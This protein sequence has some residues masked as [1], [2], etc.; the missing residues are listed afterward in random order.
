MSTQFE[1]PF[2]YYRL[3]LKLLSPQLGTCTEASIY[4]EHVLK[5]AQK[6]IKEAN[7][8]SGKLTKLADKY[9]GE[10][11]PENKQVE[12][13]KGIIKRQQEI[14]GKADIL[15]STITEL[16]AYASTLDE[17]MKELVAKGEEKRP[18]IF[19]RDPKTGEVMISTHMLLGNLKENCRNFINNNTQEKD[20]LPIKSKVSIGEM[21][22]CDVKAVEYFVHPKDEN[23]KRIDVQKTADG[24]IELNER[25]ITFEQM[26]KKVSAIAMSES[27]PEGAEYEMHLRVRKSSP[28]NKDDAAFLRLLLSLG[29]S[30][31][32]GQWRGSGS[33][34]QYVYKLELLNNFEEKIPEGW[35]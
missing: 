34:G 8:Q 16:L 2:V 24:K 28:V 19:M 23:G 3:K 35:N 1:S 10:E 27:I 5:K 17:E 26:G 6:L 25:P 29:R 22:A 13:L 33:K 21:F 9:K 20:K 18:T 11:I 32:L 7:K 4:E 14:L 31:G 30:N 15:P 12:E